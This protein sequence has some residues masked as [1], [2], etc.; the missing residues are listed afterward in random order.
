MKA[1]GIFGVMI[2]FLV[3]CSQNKLGQ[4]Q[5]ADII[6]SGK[7]YPRA[8]EYE[9][10]TADPVVAKKLLDAGLEE[11]GM[12]TVDRSQKL[13]DV[14]RPLVH[15][16]DKAEPYLLR[17]DSHYKQDQIVKIADIDLGEITGIR[18]SEDNKKAVVEYTVVYKNITPFAKLIHR[19]LTLPETQ[20]AGLT[21]FDTGWKLD[22]R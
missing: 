13:K 3:A 11:D 16:T 5:A 12:V 20:R 18:M 7:S 17:I 15:F 1:L 14:G 9:I 21:L 2:F 4:D 19:D 6:R 22:K 10:S 8:F